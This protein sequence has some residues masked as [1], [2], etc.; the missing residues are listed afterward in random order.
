MI[1]HIKILAGIQTL[2]L[3]FGIA[4]PA[5]AAVQIS[6][7][8][9]SQSASVVTIYRN[10]PLPYYYYY[11]YSTPSQITVKPVIQTTSQNPV[12]TNSISNTI[13]ASNKVSLKGLLNN[14]YTIP[15]KS[16]PAPTPTP[17]PTPAPTPTP[18]PAPTPTPTPS[19]VGPLTVPTSLTADEQSMVNMVNQERV[20]AGV[21]PVSVD[22]RIV[23]VARAK[24]Q[25]M[26]DNKY[27]AH[28]SPTFGYASSLF[29]SVGLNTNYFSENLASHNSVSEAMSNF[30][31][32]AGHR[33]NILDPNVTHIGV[34]IIYGSV[35]GNLYVQQF[36]KE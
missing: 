5:K 11:Y 32:S 30:M 27:F 34:G 23:A 20:K 17:T 3:S 10:Q 16:A 29:P 12:P 25:D 36:T 33:A 22:L 4:I 18:T 28:L 7:P 13:T 24:G 14:T 21:K 9:T 31:L 1:K 6:V 15:V 8:K 26:K 19:P 2:I 35:F